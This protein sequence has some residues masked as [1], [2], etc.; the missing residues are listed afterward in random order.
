MCRSGTQACLDEN[1]SSPLYLVLNGTH[2]LQCLVLWDLRWSHMACQ[3]YVHL[4]NIKKDNSKDYRLAGFFSCG[5]GMVHAHARSLDF[6]SCDPSFWVVSPL[7]PVFMTS[8]HG[9]QVLNEQKQ[10]SSDLRRL[11]D[12]TT[13]PLPSFSLVQS[14]PQGHPTVHGSHVSFV[15]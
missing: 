4:W 12:R 1:G 7:E 10:T 13:V 9:N 5:N 6:L 11:R 14:K 3:W 8:F 2:G 15:S